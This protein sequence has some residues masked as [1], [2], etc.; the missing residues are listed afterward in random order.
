[1]RIG[2]QVTING[3]AGITRVLVCD[4]TWTQSGSSLFCLYNLFYSAATL[5]TSDTNAPPAPFAF[6]NQTDYKIQHNVGSATAIVLTGFVDQQRL[7]GTT[8]S[9]NIAIGDIDSFRSSPQMVSSNAS[10]SITAT[11]RYGLNIK[12]VTFTATGTVVLTN[13]IGINIDD[14]V[15]GVS[16]NRT[17]TNVY[18]IKSSLS[19]GTNKWFIYHNSTAA[20]MHEGNFQIGMESTTTGELHF[21]NASNTNLVKIKALAGGGAYTLTLPTDDGTANQVLKTDGSGGLS[22]TTAA[23]TSPL[24]TKG[25]LFTYTTTD[26]RL[27]VGT[28]RQTLEVDSSTASGLKW[29]NNCGFTITGSTATVGGTS[30][31][32]LTSE[33]VACSTRMPFAGEIYAIAIGLS[34]NRTAG[35]CTARYT[36]GGTPDTTNTAVID[37]TN[38][39]NFYRLFATPVAFAAGD[40]INLQT[41]TSG[42]TPTTAD[43]LVTLFCRRT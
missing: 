19:S 3:V 37:G 10:A 4:G 28:N 14:M 31:V 36:I 30:T 8:A 25:D 7:S 33:A 39:L 29:G 13:N 5:T 43:A 1:M 40:L 21:A 42:F 26:D 11:N 34:T 35:T 27:A 32:N 22:W 24:T 6:Y 9:A 2:P 18:G 17:V 23:G 16:G 38:T 41:D 12:D 15:V 20:S